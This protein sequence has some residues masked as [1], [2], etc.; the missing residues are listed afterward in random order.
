VDVLVSSTL[1]PRRA[2]DVMPYSRAANIIVFFL[3]IVD[4]I[5]GHLCERVKWP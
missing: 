2:I 5:C 4:A 1:L 3:G